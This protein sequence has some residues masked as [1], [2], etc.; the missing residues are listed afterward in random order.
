[1]EQQL[2]QTEV[3]PAAANA[4]EEYKANATKEREALRSEVERYATIYKQSQ[5]QMD[6]ARKEWMQQIQETTKAG[7]DREMT[8]VKTMQSKQ[9]EADEKIRELEMEAVSLKAK[10]ESTDRRRNRVE[11][12]LA[13]MRTALGNKQNSGLEMMRMQTEL[14]HVR[15]RKEKLEEDYRKQSMELDELKKKLKAVA[16]QCEMEKTKLSMNYEKQISILESRLLS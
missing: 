5:T 10:M 15:E 11:E 2:T 14:T 13:E 4:L 6:D 3:G 16:R 8:L 9:R 7:N 1:M 12:E